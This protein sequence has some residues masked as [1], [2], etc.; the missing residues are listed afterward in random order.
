VEDVFALVANL[1]NDPIWWQS[2]V[3]S[4]VES[5]DEAEENEGN[6]DIE[7]VRDD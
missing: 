1:E 5:E 6:S 2:M 3:E 4:V 7:R